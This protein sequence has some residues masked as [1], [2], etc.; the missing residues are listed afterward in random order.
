MTLIVTPQDA[1]VLKFSEESGAS[2][3]MVLRSA[4]DYY[5]GLVT[6]EAV[7][8]QYMFDRFGIEVPPK[9]PYGVTSMYRAGAAGEVVSDLRE[10]LEYSRVHSVSIPGADDV[11]D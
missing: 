4:K 8:L 6:T 5:K 10:N 3:D 11:E 9:L 1:L 2:M 7:T